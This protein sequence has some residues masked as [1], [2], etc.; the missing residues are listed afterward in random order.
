ML[1][2]LAGRSPD[3]AEGYVAIGQVVGPWGVRGEVK[4]NLHTD[5]PERFKTTAVVYLG[6][7]AR[8]VRVLG[9]RLHKGQVLLRL[10]GYTTREAAEALR[11][12]WV[13]VP[14]D[15]VMPLAE[16][17]HYVFD[18]IGL[19][20]HTTD[21][22]LLGA[23]TEVLFTDANEV[24][25]VQ[26]EAGEVLIPYLSAVVAAEDMAAREIVIHPLPGLLD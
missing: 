3:I 8:P 14:R 25:V 5:F 1:E 15:Q 11:N 21:G 26:G 24:L 23:V 17:E 18:M 2:S 7:E 9:S 10:E 20:V 4:V 13:Q 16:G 12:L 22:R 19:Q 6:P